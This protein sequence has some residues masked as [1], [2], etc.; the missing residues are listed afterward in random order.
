[1]GQGSFTRN[2]KSFA[3]FIKSFQ[4]RLFQKV[5]PILCSHTLR[6]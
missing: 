4:M 3:K 5:T 2:G 1:L 6:D